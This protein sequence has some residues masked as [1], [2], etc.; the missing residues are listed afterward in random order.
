MMCSD[1]LS[2]M[3]R[4][5]EI[6]SVLENVPE[7]LEACRELTDRANSA[8]GHDNITVIV[9]R[10]GEGFP[11]PA[12]RSDLRYQ[13]FALPEISQEDPQDRASYEPPDGT[14][15]SEEARKEDRKLRVSHTMIGV[16]APSPHQLIDT[17]GGQ[18][19]R[20][21]LDSVDGAE[22]GVGGRQR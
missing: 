15:L 11:S 6:Q 20:S 22:D 21:Q 8:G 1:G 5:D 9:A 13:K 10:F 18:K 14:E 3:I 2:G 7:P 17:V 4:A 19:R 16:A 12:G